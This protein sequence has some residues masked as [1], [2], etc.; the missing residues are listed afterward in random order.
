MPGSPNACREQFAMIVK[1]LPHAVEK[2]QDRGGDCAPP[3][4]T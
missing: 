1:A 4:R 3:P 2:L